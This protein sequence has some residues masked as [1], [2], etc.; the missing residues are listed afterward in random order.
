MVEGLLEGQ[1]ETATEV[2]PKPL[3]SLILGERRRGG[4]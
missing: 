4:G 2:P 3:L 1:V